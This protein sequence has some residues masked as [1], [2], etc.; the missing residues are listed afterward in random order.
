MKYC[1]RE[2]TLTD[3]PAMMEVRM[4]VRENILSD[5]KKVQE[6]DYLNILDSAGKGWVCETEQ[7]MTGFAVADLAS[8]NIWALFVLPEHEQ[9]G[10]GR[11]LHQRMLDWCFNQEGISQLWLSTDPGTRAEKFYLKA[12]WQKKE[13]LENGEQL[14]EIL[15]S[16]WKKNEVPLPL[17]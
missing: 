16:R 4:A 12:G 17:P 1:Y 13:I 2:A 3:F 11:G 8:G 15:R 14:F 10:I 9:K 6:H 5:P 7:G